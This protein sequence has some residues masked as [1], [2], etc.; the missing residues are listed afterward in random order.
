MRFH[1]CDGFGEIHFLSAKLACKKN[2]SEIFNCGYGKGYS[3]KE[4]IKSFEIIS[5]EKL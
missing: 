5:K 4:V 1:S 2:I 3:I